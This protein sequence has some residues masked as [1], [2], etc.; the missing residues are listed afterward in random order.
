MNSSAWCMLYSDLGFFLLV[1]IVSASIAKDF[2]H[3]QP[4]FSGSATCFDQALSRKEKDHQPHLFTFPL[5]HPS[6]HFVSRSARTTSALPR[7]SSR[8][9][10]A[11]CPRTHRPPSTLR[12][13]TGSSV[14]HL[15]EKTKRSQQ[16]SS[17]RCG[18]MPSYMLTCVTTTCVCVKCVRVCVCVCVCVC[19]CAHTRAHVHTHPQ[20]T[21]H[22]HTRSRLHRILSS[23]PC[24]HAHHLLAVSQ[25]PTERAGSSRE[26]LPHLLQHQ[27]AAHSRSRHIQHQ[28]VRGYPLFQNIFLMLYK[29]N[30]R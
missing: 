12:S 29:V 25:P 24:A 23:W 19:L 27:R 15:C 16:A 21:S 6:V 13:G 17:Q 5:L 30:C 11:S 28:R 14:S 10:C 26:K 9:L 1:Q 3:P 22:T 20:T 8:V 7:R 2:L 18:S 4:A